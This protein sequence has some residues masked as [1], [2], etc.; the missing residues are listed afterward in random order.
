MIHSLIESNF[1]TCFLEKLTTLE[2]YQSYTARVN[3]F[4]RHRFERNQYDQRLVKFSKPPIMSVTLNCTR[5]I[6]LNRI[7]LLQSVGKM[8]IKQMK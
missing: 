6:G 4:D 1:P 7:K 5:H 8:Y 3:H 2:I